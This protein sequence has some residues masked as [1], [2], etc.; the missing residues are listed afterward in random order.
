MAVGTPHPSSL[1]DSRKGQPTYGL[2][3]ALSRPDAKRRRP[4]YSR[5]HQL[6]PMNLEN[7]KFICPQFFSVEY[8]C[9]KVEGALLSKLQ[10]K[11]LLITATMILQIFMVI[12]QSCRY[13]NLDD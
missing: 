8:E 9:F 11:P 6:E 7:M 13:L 1:P 4:Q 3:S 2:A 10:D 5:Y 12:A